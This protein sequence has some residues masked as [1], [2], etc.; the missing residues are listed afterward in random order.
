MTQELLYSPNDLKKFFHTQQPDV[1]IHLAA[2]GNMSYQKDEAMIVFANIIGTFN[3]LQASKDINYKA[4]I[5]FGSS[6]EYGRKSLPMSEK[7]VLKPE[8]FYGASKAGATQLCLAFAKQYEK[9]ILVV[10][11]FSVYGPGEADFRFIPT[12]IQHMVTNKVFQCNFTANHDWIFID[13][14]VEAVLSLI[15]RVANLNDKVINIGSGRMHTNKEICEAL[16]KISGVQYLATAMTGTRPNDSE[17]WISDN[18]YI[19]RLGWYPKHM[20]QEGLS[21]T[22]K[23]Y[24]DI[25]GK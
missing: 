19:N 7:D 11:P 8:T 10:R 5:Q 18:S 16:K 2:F 24:K 14:F 23:Y 9:P 4:F 3:M 12:A 1:I 13:D 21:E 6:S 17:V 25:Y 15:P 20:L 22:W